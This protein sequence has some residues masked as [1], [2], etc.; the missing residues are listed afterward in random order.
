M[1]KNSSETYGAF[2]K[3]MHWL[4]ALLIVI[5][6][7]V[8]FY[9][10]GFDK[11]NLAP[12]QIQMIGMHKAFG[13][14]AM[15]LLVVRLG[16][17]RLSPAPQLPAVFTPKEKRLVS[18]VKGMLYLL[19]FLAPLSGYVMSTASGRPT[20]FFGLFN[21]PM[22]IGENKALA[23]FAHEAHEILAFLMI[24]FIVVHMAGAIKHRLK[25]RNGPSDILARM[26]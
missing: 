13:A 14:L 3:L 21:L 26:L 24:A 5:L 22:L 2:S 4:M 6:L 11:E 23:G 7:A 18:G 20:S 12:S 10:A 8:G 25:D 9:I 1:L 17:L 19:M 16:W 15:L